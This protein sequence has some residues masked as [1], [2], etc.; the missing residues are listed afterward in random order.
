MRTVPPFPSVTSRLTRSAS[1]AYSRS[2]SSGV[3]PVPLSSVSLIMGARLRN[4]LAGCQSVSA[5]RLL[6][7]GRCMPKPTHL[8]GG[9][10]TWSPAAA[11]LAIACVACEQSP[12]PAGEPASASCADA[13]V[14]DVVTGFGSRLQRVSTLAPDSLIARAVRDE[15]AAFVTDDLLAQ[16]T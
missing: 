13:A 14:R 16:W 8:T 10:R 9:L 4:A 1:S 12:E 3:A 11:M 15:Y 7:G 5:E 6:H 2:H